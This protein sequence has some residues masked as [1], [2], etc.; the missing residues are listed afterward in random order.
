MKVDQIWGENRR[1]L[2][3]F[4]RIERTDAFKND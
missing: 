4:E 3:L 2:E 1:E